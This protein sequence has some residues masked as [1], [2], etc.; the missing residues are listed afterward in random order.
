VSVDGSGTGYSSLAYLQHYSI[1]AFKA[2]QSF[3]RS[4]AQN[5]NAPSL[6][7]AIIAMAHRLNLLLESVESP[8]QAPLLMEHNCR[9]TQGLYSNPAV[10]TGNFADLP[11]KPGGIMANTFLMT[12]LAKNGNSLLMV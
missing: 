3:V 2:D 11:G 12:S 9:C 8:Q 5:A 1:N 10:L 4:I 7:N 6:A